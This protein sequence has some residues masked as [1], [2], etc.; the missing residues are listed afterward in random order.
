M[1]WT[2]VDAPVY[3]PSSLLYL[4]Q[5]QLLRVLAMDRGTAEESHLASVTHLS[6]GW[7]QSNESLLWIIKAKPHCPKLGPSKSQISPKDGLMVLFLWLHDNPTSSCSTLLLYFT[8]LD[9]GS[10]LQNSFCMLIFSQ[11][12]FQ[13]N[14]AD[15]RNQFS[16]PKEQQITHTRTHTHTQITVNS[17]KLEGKK[18]IWR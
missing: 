1:R 14:K 2:V 18:D 15:N 9:P 10:H 17:R 3:L 11:S 16:D 13:E 5:D 8:D 7:H 4:H 6:W 12:L